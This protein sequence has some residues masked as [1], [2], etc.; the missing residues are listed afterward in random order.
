M[1]VHVGV[2]AFAGNVLYVWNIS[3]LESDITHECAC[4]CDW[5]CIHAC[6]HTYIHLYICVCVCV[7]VCACPFNVYL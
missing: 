5:M 2:S 1:C 3:H 4:H 6:L 7:C